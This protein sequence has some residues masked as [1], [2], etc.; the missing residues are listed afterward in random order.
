MSSPKQIAA[1]RENG[2]KSRGPRTPAGK[3]RSN[4]NARRH[5][6]NNINRHNAAFAP[7]IAA[8]ARAI[9]PDAGNALVYEQALI[10]G[11]ATC[12]VS[13]VRTMRTERMAQAGRLRAREDANSVSA[14]SALSA[15]ARSDGELEAMHLTIAELE[16]LY[17]YERRALSRRNRAVQKLIEIRT[18][19]ASWS[20]TQCSPGTME[21]THCQPLTS[22]T[23]H[24][25]PVTRS[26]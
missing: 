25:G 13:A 14:V 7:R 15:Q 18:T 1:N 22:A 6:L 12:V 19:M 16:R 26:C 23:T 24:V 5:G 21:R 20:Q 17:R 9:C 3:A 4:G 11:E 2:R 10:I 8:I